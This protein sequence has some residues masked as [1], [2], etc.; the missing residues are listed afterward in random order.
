MWIDSLPEWS[1]A[2][3]HIVRTGGTSIVV[4][5]HAP[6]AVTLIR[7]DFGRH[8]LT[9]PNMAEK[10]FT[11]LILSVRELMLYRINSEQE[12][13]TDPKRLLDG[14]NPPS[15]EALETLLQATQNSVSKNPLRK[16]PIEVQDAILNQV[17]AGPIESARVGC[18]LDA[19]SAFTWRCNNRNVEREE[20]RRSRT[21]WT[22]VESHIWFGDHPSGVAYK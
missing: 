15:D 13:Y 16:L 14:I 21:P 7:K 18:L 5:Q 3:A 17:S 22:P 10:T 6:H 2:S 11:Y 12:R 4:C 8:I 9:T 19:G 1:F 20:G